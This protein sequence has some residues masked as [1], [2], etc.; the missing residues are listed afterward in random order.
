MVP[1]SALCRYAAGECGK[2]WHRPPTFLYLVPEAMNAQNTEIVKRRH[3]PALLGLGERRGGKPHP[4]RGDVAPRL[5]AAV[6]KN[7]SFSRRMPPL[8]EQSLNLR[9]NRLFTQLS[10]SRRVSRTA[11]VGHEDA[12]PTTTL[13]IRSRLGKPTVAGTRGNEQDAPI[14]VIRRCMGNRPGAT[15]PVLPPHRVNFDRF[16][17]PK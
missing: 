11:G 17:T 8:R 6:G 10:R 2:G 12:F 7:R 13:S 3:R 5:G 16:V 9:R 1:L 14:G 4:H 15:K